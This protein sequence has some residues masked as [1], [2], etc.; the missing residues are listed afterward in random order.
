VGEDIWVSGT[1]IRV[2]EYFNLDSWSRMESHA[3]EGPNFCSQRG[4]AC[5][6]FFLGRT[7]LCYCAVQAHV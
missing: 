4:I 6:V 7:M 2:Y 5:L 3:L 1:S